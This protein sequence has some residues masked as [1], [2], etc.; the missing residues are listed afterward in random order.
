[1]MAYVTLIAI[2]RIVLFFCL[3][4]ALISNVAGRSED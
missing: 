3:P 2:Q 1:M 4:H